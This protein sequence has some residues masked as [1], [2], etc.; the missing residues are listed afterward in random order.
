MPTGD[1]VLQQYDDD[2]V[3]RVRILKADDVAAMTGELLDII[4]NDS[5]CHGH[6]HAIGD[7]ASRDGDALTLHASNG[8]WVYRLADHDTEADVW[9][10]SK[11]SGPDGEEM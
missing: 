3:R 7:C 11:L 8:T 6:S 2:G 10:L 9:T 4:T 5:A 1:V